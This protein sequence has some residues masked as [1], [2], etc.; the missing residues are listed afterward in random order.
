[1]AVD[2][3][4]I[5]RRDTALNLWAPTA[6][7]DAVGSLHNDGAGGLTWSSSGGGIT[8][9]V[10]ST[11]TA[12]VR[13]DDALGT[14]VRDSNVTLANSGTA[15]VFSG[16]GGISA[17]G[18]N[19]NVTLTPSGT[20]KSVLVGPVQLSGYGV[21]V[22]Q[23]DASGNLTVGSVSATPGGSNTQIQF[24][25]SGAFGGDSKL[26]FDKSTGQTVVTGASS[27]TYRTPLL[28]QADATKGVEFSFNNIHAGGTK[29]TQ[30]SFYSQNNLQ[31]AF[32]NDS[33]ENG[34]DDFWIYQASASDFRFQIL[35]TGSI[36]L[37]QYGAGILQC[38]SSGIVLSDFT[39]PKVYANAGSTPSGGVSGT[40]IWASGGLPI[41][42]WV[43]SAATAGSRVWDLLA[44]GG[45]LHI[46]GVTDAYSGASDLMTFTHAGS[47]AFPQ[48]ALT[49][50]L[51]IAIAT[52]SFPLT[53]NGTVVNILCQ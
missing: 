38:D 17:G 49:T 12:L 47:V 33:P 43:E 23:S 35:S 50:G 51:S 39:V 42:S 19:Q 41:I 8:G 46:R 21:G 6:L 45:V 7:A 36:R 28:I 4:I 40:T 24:N 13:W 30:L 3:T 14:A 27:S 34:T 44:S 1:M 37:K 48:I 31:W 52:K 16:A 53:I 29:K 5:L 18:S 11:I 15:L 2:T 32:G 25:D 9:P 20:G 10:S 26:T 22:V